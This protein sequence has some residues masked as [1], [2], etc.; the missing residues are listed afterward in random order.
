MYCAPSGCRPGVRA[1]PAGE[2][3][4]RRFAG[5]KNTLRP[6]LT[7]ADAAHRVLGTR[8]MTSV[9]KGLH[10]LGLPQWLPSMPR[11]YRMPD[12][13]RKTPVPEPDK[14]VYFPS[15]INQTMGLARETPVAEPLAGKM[16]SRC[17]ARR[18][19]R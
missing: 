18:A 7:M 11:A 15:C 19:M 16:G 13:L 10:A 3:A 2:F 8:A 12:A 17:S 5:L 9:T 14:V 4:A 1:M 6:V